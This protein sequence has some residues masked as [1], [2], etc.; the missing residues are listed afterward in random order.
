MSKT[1]GRQTPFWTALVRGLA[2]VAIQG[3]LS[4]I[5]LEIGARIFDPAGLSYYPATAAFMTR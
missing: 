5:L 1:S 3:V 2:F 4:L